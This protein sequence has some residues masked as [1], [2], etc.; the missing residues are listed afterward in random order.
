VTG[1]GLW[2][3][4]IVTAG[5]LFGN[6]PWVQQNFSLIVWAMIIVPGLLALAGAWRAR[7]R[8]ALEAAA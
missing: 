5:Y 2:V 1:G 3:G 8:A 6:L 4:S 7:R